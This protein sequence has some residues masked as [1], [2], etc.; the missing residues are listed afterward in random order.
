MELL[1]RGLVS[2]GA[3]RPAN[4]APF[5]VKNKGGK[6]RLVIDTH[7][8]NCKFVKPWHTSLPTPGA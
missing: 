5:F 8:I 1:E 7:I 2:F 3:L 4:C 6:I